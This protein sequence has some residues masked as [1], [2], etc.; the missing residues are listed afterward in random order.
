M[1]KARVRDLL[2]QAAAT[3]ACASDAP[4]LEAEVLL[5]CT[6]NRSRCHLH[7]WPEH[8][9]EADQAHRFRA[10]LARRQRGEPIAYITGHREFW[11]MDLLV[12]PATLIPRPETELLVEIALARI[13]EDRAARIAD[14]GTGSG[15]IALA[16]A[17]ERQR[18]RVVA[19]DASAPALAIARHNAERLG[20]DNVEFRQSDW[21]SEL[22]AER[23]DA[24]LANP[25]YVAIA[26]PHLECGDLRFE[27]RVAL[28]AGADGLDAIR[29][30]AAGAIAHLNPGGWL[31][32][33]HGFDQ[34]EGVAA[35]LQTQGLVDISQHRD[36]AYL[37]R[38]SGGRHARD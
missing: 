24:I 23:F 31:L 36:M 10:L 22:G 33:E 18:S 26:D 37:I 11:S 8:T 9:P 3:L 19:T 2:N 13:P 15:A 7:A 29:A 38:V 12:T 17:R 21:Y 16:I 4:R 5:A 20:L 30:I 25:P 6:L 27:P 14:L 28:A 35:L 32:L 1:A 34:G